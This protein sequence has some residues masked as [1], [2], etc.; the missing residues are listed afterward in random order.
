MTAIIAT[1][2]MEIEKLRAVSEEFSCMSD[3]SIT[4]SGKA[5]W[6]FLSESINRQIKHKLRMI[7]ERR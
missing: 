4:N 5:G 7:K 6:A 1:L 3:H 2:E